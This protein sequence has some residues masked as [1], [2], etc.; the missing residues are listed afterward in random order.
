M[1]ALSES[2]LFNSVV[3]T[4]PGVAAATGW[5]GHRLMNLGSFGARFASVVDDSIGGNRMVHRGEVVDL[6][7]K[8]TFSAVFSKDTLD[9][10]G[11]G[12]FMVAAKHNG[13]TGQAIYYPTATTVTG[14]TVPSNGAAVAGTIVFARGFRNLANNG[15]KIV[16]AAS[17]T[18]ITVVG[19][20]VVE[21]PL[22]GAQVDIVGRRA[23]AG[24]IG[25]DVNGDLTSA[26]GI[27]TAL[28]LA[29]GQH[30]AIGGDEPGTNFA[31]ALYK[32][33]AMVDVITAN[34]LTLKDR[35]WAVGAADTGAAK[36]IDLY[37]GRWIRNVSAQALDYLESTYT[38]ELATPKL[39]PAGETMFHYSQG[40]L[41]ASARINAQSAAKLE[42]EY[43]FQGR[44]TIDP[45]T[46]RLPGASAAKPMQQGAM[47]NTAT[48]LRRIR[49]AGVDEVGLSTDIKDLSVTIGN[50]VN[51][52][53]LL[54]V[55]GAGYVDV[56]SFM[57]QWQ[58]TPIY[59]NAEMVAA[60][61]D[62]RKVSMEMCG[63]NGDGGFV[64]YSPNCQADEADPNLPRN[65]SMTLPTTLTATE[66]EIYGYM[67]GITIFGYLPKY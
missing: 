21:T 9:D 59:T 17:G 4:A 2:I 45:S 11:E 37:F 16:G 28:G 52:E 51:R 57:T 39:G 56:G 47:F 29:V 35:S 58:L 18:E 48:G 26:A 7:V 3:E 8:P 60:V 10:F 1:R 64:L 22:P 13:G 43:T 36:T 34:K 32:A 15:K 44:T 23:A 50:S 42:I 66:D 5:R 33:T 38:F 61:R 31:N 49:V 54:G 63:R 67:T 12:L 20:L 46:V 30:I 41:V 25:L 65:M 14:Y 19:G 55:L 24:D 40:N 53:T 62:K 27:F 6:D